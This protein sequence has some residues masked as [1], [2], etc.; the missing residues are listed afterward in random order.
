ML[1]KRNVSNKMCK[2]ISWKFVLK[3]LCKFATDKS[4]SVISV[5]VDAKRILFSL[6]DH[7]Q[8]ETH[9]LNNQDNLNLETS[10]KSANKFSR[11][12]IY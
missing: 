6:N 5:I 8:I 1:E 3:T 11:K 4:C 7:K 10:G 9:F 12:D 2:I